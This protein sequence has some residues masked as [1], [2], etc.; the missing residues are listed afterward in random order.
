MIWTILILKQVH[1][2]NSKRNIDFGIKFY[3][4]VLLQKVILSEFLHVKTIFFDVM[5]DQIFL[6]ILRYF[7]DID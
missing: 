7:R 2:V 3:I 4:T 5:K 1:S 6:V